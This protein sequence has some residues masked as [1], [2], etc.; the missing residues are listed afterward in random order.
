MTEEFELGSEIIERIPRGRDGAALEAAIRARIKE[1]IATERKV[2]LDGATTG[3]DSGFH[4]GSRVTLTFADP[5]HAE[6]WFDAFADAYDAVNAAPAGSAAS[7][8]QT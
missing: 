4:S 2:L 6:K 5:E 3:Y 1:L 8:E 7:G